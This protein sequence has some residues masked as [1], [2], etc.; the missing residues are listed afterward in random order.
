MLSVYLLLSE[1]GCSIAWASLKLL[2]FLLPLPKCWDYSCVPPGSHKGGA[3]IDFDDQAV[4]TSDPQMRSFPVGKASLKA[5][6]RFFL[7]MIGTEAGACF[8]IDDGE[9]K[10]AF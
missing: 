4:Q 9:I 7:R 2:L 5:L 1:I 8:E 10:K 3:G 6:W